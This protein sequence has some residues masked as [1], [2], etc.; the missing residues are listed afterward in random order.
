MKNLA[1]F[2]VFAL[3]FAGCVSETETTYEVPV[4]APLE[5]TP[6]PIPE[7][8]EEEVD[9]EELPVPEVVVE[10]N[11]TEE[12]IVHWDVGVTEE[13]DED[14]RKLQAVEFEAGYALIVD[15]LTRDKP[16]PCAALR[17]GKLDGAQIETVFQDKVCPGEDTYWT[18]PE[19]DT[20]RI[21]VFETA[22]GY[23]GY[24]YWADVA[25]YKQWKK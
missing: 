13:I 10:E 23:L 19:G 20:Y 2:L 14:E 8:H 22:A 3:L 15:D 16:Y 9:S 5:Q 17:I 11:I 24:V 25:V 12:E 6:E 18:S 7:I 1:F 4:A 21:H